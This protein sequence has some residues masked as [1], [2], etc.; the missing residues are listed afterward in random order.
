[1]PEHNEPEHNEQPAAT[2][3]A[4]DT[5]NDIVIDVGCPDCGYNLRGLPGPVVNC[6]E[7]GLR[8]DVPELAARQWNKPWYRA[9]GFNTLMWPAGWMWSVGI[10]GLPMVET[11]VPSDILSYAA[12]LLFVVVWFWLMVRAWKLLS[13]SVGLWLALLSHVLV[14]GY[15]V[16]TV[17]V[18]SV[19]LL[20]IS[21]AT[22]WNADTL[23]VVYTSLAFAAFALLLWGSRRV[24][25]AIAGV[26]IRHYLLRRPT[27]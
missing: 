18:I 24:E 2:V 23:S 11:F 19:V 7:C 16:G 22:D 9:P 21:E 5:A 26:C 13:G 6:P 14:A 8:S 25:R 27:G 4:D 3:P 1:M 17:G 20:A 10:I 15:L 12:G